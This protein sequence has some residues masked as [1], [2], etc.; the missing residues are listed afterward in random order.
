MAER[1]RARL[2]AVLAAD[3][4]LEL[5]LAAAAALDRD[6]HQVADAVLVEHLER[7]ALEDAVLEV[8]GEELPLGVVA[9]EA[10]RRLGEVVRAERAEVG[11]LGDLVGPDARARQLD[12]RA[13]QVRDR[14]LLRRDALGQLPQPRAAPRGSR[15]AG[16]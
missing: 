12:H 8:V 13:A 16:A 2:A 15:R 5:G 4:H 1:D 6:P 14:G 7:V 9:R 11:D 3:P 10:E